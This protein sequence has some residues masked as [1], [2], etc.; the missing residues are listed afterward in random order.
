[1]AELV[2]GGLKPKKQS[3]SRKHDAICVALYEQAEDISRWIMA[4]QW[5]AGNR[6]FDF[7]NIELES[8]IRR[9]ARYSKYDKHDL[10][11]KE[12]IVGY[13]DLLVEGWARS[14]EFPDVRFNIIFEV[15]PTI[16]SMG[17]L[18]RQAHRYKSTI[19][20]F[21]KQDEDEIY[22]CVVSSSVEFK[23]VIEDKGH[24]FIDTAWLKEPQA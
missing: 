14:D 4:D 11:H 18:L 15:K 24:Y 22:I 7:H 8:P 16:S 13:V 21:N 19:G 1:M 12:K 23:K 2:D 10:I 17:E 3:Q 6:T 5:G 20:D 9:P